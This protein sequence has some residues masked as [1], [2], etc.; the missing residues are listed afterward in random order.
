MEIAG[1]EKT[2]LKLESPKMLKASFQTGY[3]CVLGEF[4]RLRA[5]CRETQFPTAREI[6]EDQ[7][8]Q[9]YPEKST[10]SVRLKAAEQTAWFSVN[11][12]K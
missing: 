5:V 4:F 3:C 9:N 11:F 8:V 1:F 7:K 12:G 2:Y 6:I 10:S